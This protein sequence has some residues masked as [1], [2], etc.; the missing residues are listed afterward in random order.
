MILNVDAETD[1]PIVKDKTSSTAGDSISTVNLI[2][3]QIQ[4]SNSLYLFKTSLI[5]QS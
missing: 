4:T 1:W 2:P 5:V 3:P